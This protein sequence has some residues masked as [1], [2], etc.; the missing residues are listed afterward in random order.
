MENHELWS[1]IL[2]SAGAKRVADVTGYDQSTVYRFGRHPF[3]SEHLDGTG[4]R[5]ILD[6]FEAVVDVL[7]SRRQSRVTLRKL[8]HWATGV[9]ERASGRDESNSESSEQ[10]SA[11]AVSALRELADV[12]D[13]CR[14]GNPDEDRLIHECLEVEAILEQIRRAAEAR[15]VSQPTQLRRVD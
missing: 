2:K 10:L 4:E 14:K 5:G 6:R 13:E 15:G 3:D 9:F 7:A 1:E 12:I 8:Q 11:R